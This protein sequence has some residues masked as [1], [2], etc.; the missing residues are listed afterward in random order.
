MGDVGGGV[1][2]GGRLSRSSEDG[3]RLGFDPGFTIPLPVRI[4]SRMLELGGVYR[5]KA[6]DWTTLASEE[7]GGEELGDVAVSA[8]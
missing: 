5:M 3:D 1:A 7:V 2:L 8:S 4:V 6:A